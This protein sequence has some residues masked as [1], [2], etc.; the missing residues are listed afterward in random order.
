VQPIQEAI[1]RGVVASLIDGVMALIA[2]GILLFYSVTL[3]AIVVFALIM[4]GSDVSAGRPDAG[5]STFASVMVD[6]AFFSASWGLSRT[7]AVDRCSVFAATAG[8]PF[9]VSE[10]VLDDA[11]AGSTGRLAAVMLRRL[12]PV[13]SMH[14]SMLACGS[15]G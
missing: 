5:A 4:T 11:G 7:W 9:V 14:A 8:F 13:A 12:S 2:A 1:T 15:E 3:G 6:F 10:L